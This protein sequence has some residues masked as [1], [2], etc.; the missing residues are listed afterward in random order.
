MCYSIDSV[1]FACIVAVIVPNAL[2]IITYLYQVMV[3]V[4]QITG[5]MYL[6][7]EMVY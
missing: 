5:A 3:A 6:M 4:L 2:I 1:V 7:L